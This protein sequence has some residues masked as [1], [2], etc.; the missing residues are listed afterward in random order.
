MDAD[1]LTLAYLGDPN[2]I[3]TRRWA[4]WF[5]A[6][7]HDVYLLV[8]TDSSVTEGLHPSIRVETFRGFGGGRGP[9]RGAPATRRSLRRRL[10]SIGPAILHA[11]YLTTAGWQG[12]LAGV[13][14]F[15][16]TVWGTDVYR[17]ARPLGGRLQA[18]LVLGAADLVTADSEDLAA[19]T[20]ALGA[21]AE[22]VHV[23]QFGVDSTLF[24]P[25]RD[26][27]PLRDRLGLAGRRIVFSP[28]TIAPLY[29]H[30][31]VLEALAGLPEDVIG[32]FSASATR[33]G[34][35]ARLQAHAAGLGLTDRIRILDRIDH[36]EMA[37]HLALADV[38]VSVPESDATPV[39]LLEAM[40]VGR[41]IVASDTPSVRAL[42]APVDPG[43][44]VPI[45]DSEATRLAIM[46]RLAW[47]PEQRREFGELART[48]VLRMADQDVN[49]GIVERLYRDLAGRRRR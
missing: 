2:S 8:P 30:G 36:D 47:S 11:H 41:P 14:P 9:F 20:V 40:A 33:E 44:L 1:R 13:H 49:M 38:V 19:A 43:A 46:A 18:R 12:W 27:G 10:R 22:R 28:R 45:G 29:R 26:P 24:R 35:L 42:L 5:A 39:T 3:H 16:V 15:V 23:V 32:L 17:N 25:D 37:D 31:T 6:H 48:I 34:E 21:R 4:G 7:G